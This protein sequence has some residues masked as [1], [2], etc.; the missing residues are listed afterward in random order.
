MIVVVY[1]FLCVIVGV[2][3][4]RR[5]PGLLGYFLLSIPLTPVVTLIFLLATQKRFL[6]REGLIAS[7]MVSCGHCRHQQRQATA[8]AYCTHCG[9]PL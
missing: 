8:V 6:E 1:L 3:G 5:R 9:R 7:Q 4:R 2:T